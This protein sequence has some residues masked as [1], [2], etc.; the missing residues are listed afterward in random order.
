MQ[1]LVHP[2]EY[3]Y[4]TLGIFWT[5]FVWLIAVTLVFDPYE[6]VLLLLFVMLQHLFRLYRTAGSLRFTGA[7]VTE[8]QFP[9]VYRFVQNL[10]ARMGLPMPE[11]YIRQEGGELNARAFRLPGLAIVVISADLAEIIYRKG[12]SA[13]AFVIAHELAHLKLW[14]NLKRLLIDPVYLPIPALGLLFSPLGLAYS[15]ACELT[16]DRVAAS[17]FPAGGLDAIRVLLAGKRLYVHASAEEILERY[18]QRDF[19]YL[20]VELASD[21]PLLPTRLHALVDAGLVTLP[22]GAPRAPVM[23]ATPPLREGAS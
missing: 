17:F 19:S 4:F 10:A 9:E 23:L 5:F 11:V 7:R 18:G 8:Q 12:S 15:R 1:F 22:T 16:C 2:K 3:L 6:G 21:H 14:H 13:V 20:L